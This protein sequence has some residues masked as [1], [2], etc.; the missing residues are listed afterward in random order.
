MKPNLAVLIYG[1]GDLRVVERPEP[2]PAAHEAVIGMKL[3]GICG[4]DLR[5]WRHGGREGALVRDPMVLG[6]EVVGVVLQPALDGSGPCT[7]TTVV[8]HPGTPG[9]GDGSRYPP[10]RPNLSPGSTYLGSASRYPHADGAF[11]RR[12]ALPSR[13]LWTIPAGVTDEDAALVE[14]ASVAWHAVSRAGDLAGRR[15]AVL[16]C[17]PIGL[18]IISVLRNH[19]A[20][21]I[22]AIDRHAPRLSRA[23]TCGALTTINPDANMGAVANVDADIVFEATGTTTGF[24]TSMRIAARGGRVVVVGL[25]AADRYEQAVAL[26]VTRELEVLGSFRF[27]DEIRQVIGALADRSLMLQGIVSH[28][29]PIEEAEAAFQVAS[30]STESSKVLLDF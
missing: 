7:G 22:V 16:G 6:H 2:S 15:V 29:F 28:R 21:D 9:P 8:V 5:Y 30:D 14:P 20:T 24:A 11:I 17:G 18:A 26:V 25:P 10:H 13:M 12:L 23:R 4:S 19:A 1:K 27:N 3:G